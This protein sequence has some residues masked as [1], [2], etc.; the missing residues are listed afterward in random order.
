M[1]TM[2]I[3]EGEVAVFSAQGEFELHV[4]WCY[5]LVY[6]RDLHD[7][8]EC[9]RSGMVSSGVGVA[10]GSVMETLGLDLTTAASH[11]QH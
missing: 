6:C 9:E 2:I 3:R 4:S 7:Q 8:L 11:L 5:I 10:R 1:R